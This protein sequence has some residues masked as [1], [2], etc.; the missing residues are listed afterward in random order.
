[1][2]DFDALFR[3]LQGADVRYIVIGGMAGVFHG[4]ARVTYDIDV[5]YER[6]EENFARIV[7]AL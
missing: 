2:T 7:E 4:A 3:S 1:M 5:V 6:S